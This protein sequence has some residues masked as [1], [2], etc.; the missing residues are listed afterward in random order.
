MTKI[1]SLPSRNHT[2]LL[3]K[4]VLN[5]PI[6]YKKQKK[7]DLIEIKGKKEIKPFNYKIPGDISSAAFFIVLTLL[8][9]NS[10]LII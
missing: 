4:N 10:K 2:E 9:E 8:S 6:K 3:F 7:Y 1:K 5:V